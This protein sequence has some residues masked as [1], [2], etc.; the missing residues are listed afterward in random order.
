[1]LV[2]DLN[3]HVKGW[4][5]EVEEMRKHIRTK[6]EDEVGLLQLNMS[7]T[8]K[9]K[10][11]RRMYFCPACFWSAG[12]KKLE[13]RRE[14][15]NYAVCSAQ[16]SQMGVVLMSTWACKNSVRHAIVETVALA[17][18]LTC[19]ES[20]WQSHPYMQRREKRTSSQQ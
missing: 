1:M 11:A 17:G 19:A 5:N 16:G 2:D 20:C 15:W 12:F 4:I 3:I 10:K 8:E 13:P 18:M 14:N 9:G 7:G 6:L